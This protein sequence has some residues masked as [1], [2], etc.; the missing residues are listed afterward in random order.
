MSEKRKVGAMTGAWVLSPDGGWNWLQL[1]LWLV[2]VPFVSAA[3]F[4]FAALMTMIFRRRGG[5]FYSLFLWSTIVFGLYTAF[6]IVDYLSYRYDGALAISPINQGVFQMFCPPEDLYEPYAKFKLQEG[7]TE[8]ELKFRHK[9]G[10]R[11]AVVLCVANC[12]PKEFDYDHP[13]VI[14]LSFGGCL[15]RMDGPAGSNFEKSYD[16]YY[17]L[18]GQNCLELLS[19]RIDHRVDLAPTNRLTVKVAGDVA[20]F[21]RHYPGSHLSVRNRTVK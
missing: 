13:D 12:R 1:I 6:N 10:G 11:Q 5:L 21:L 9:Y 20:A 7:K 19:Y 4:V 18:P 17:L 2:A 3:F 14:G 8:Y 15:A 16:S